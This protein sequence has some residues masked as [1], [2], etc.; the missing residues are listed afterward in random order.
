M[1][2]FIFPNVLYKSGWLIDLRE[3]FFQFGV[4]TNHIQPPTDQINL[5]K[6]PPKGGV[7]TRGGRLDG[8]LGAEW[9]GPR[10]GEVPVDSWDTSCS[11]HWVFVVV[12]CHY[13]AF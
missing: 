4:V 13:E 9:L 10:H 5:W 1:T 7:W 3:D 8:G 6:I 11:L 12:S 2:F